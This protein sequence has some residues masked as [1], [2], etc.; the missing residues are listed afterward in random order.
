[1]ADSDKLHQLVDQIIRTVSQKSGSKAP[2]RD[3]PILFTASHMKNFT[4]P[5]Y[6]EMRGLLSGR[7]MLYKSSAEIFYLQGK[8]ME[9]F[10]DDYPL[11]P[12]FIR[13][14]PTYREFS[15]PQLRGYFSWRAKLRR[16]ELVKAPLAYAF[17]YTYELLCGIGVASPEEGLRKL[18]WL[19]EQYERIDPRLC[20]YTKSWLND[21]VIYYGLDRSLLTGSA[22]F[23][24][25][26]A[27]IT[28]LE[29]RD[30]TPE[31]VLHALE[32][33]S[34]YK[35]TGSAFYKKY[36]EDVA[37]VTARVFSALAEYY[38]KKSPQGIFG[39]LF[40]SYERYDTF[41]FSSAVFYEKAPHPDTVYEVSG[42]T[43]YL[44][45]NGNW[46]CERFLCRKDKAGKLGILLKNIDITMRRVYR[47]PHQLKPIDCTKIFSDAIEKA[48]REFLEEKKRKERPEI[49]ID[50]SKLQS[51]RD[52]S[53]LTRKKLIV[54]EEEEAP[55]PAEP[56]APLPETGLTSVQIAVLTALLTGRNADDAARAGG[57]MLSV[58]TDSINE[59]LFDQF[60]DTVIVFEG[61]APELVEDYAE[62]LKGMV[63]L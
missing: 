58:V 13:Y 5:K 61:D 59:A 6:K 55:P 18:R 1:M 16:G 12:D 10:E 27:L 9:D 34:S 3:E 42:V 37:A 56:V 31:E 39:Q 15:L 8:Y 36:P 49:L 7:D 19:H 43:R 53:E 62:E 46:V 57:Q 63:G 24:Y 26:G 48:L 41:L 4:P 29:Y 20:R 14:F 51:I 21:Y 54:E 25:D 33:F 44:C 40:G 38:R 23:K 28:L 47:F 11:P 32:P 52:T 60:G 50:R 2:Y 35:L 30:H 22:D 17:L 45:H